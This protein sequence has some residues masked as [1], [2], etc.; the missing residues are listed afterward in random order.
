MLETVRAYAA[1]ELV[2]CGERDDAL[3]GLARYCTHEAAL[4]AEGLNGPAQSRMAGSGA[5][6]LDNYRAAMSWLIECGRPAEASDIAL[7]LRYFWMIRGHTA[8]GLRWYEQILCAP[9]LSPAGESRALVGAAGM[10]FAQGELE[11]ARPALERAL[12]LARGAGDMEIVAEAEIRLRARRTRRRPR[13]GRPRSVH[14]RPG[15]VPRA[16]H[17]VRRWKIAHRDGSA[18]AYHRRRR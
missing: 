15:G 3:E 10:W 8:E 4:A 18:R 16:E 2:A 5:R 7:A 9:S 14:H 17:A 12:A 13:T 11:R 1:L 6:R